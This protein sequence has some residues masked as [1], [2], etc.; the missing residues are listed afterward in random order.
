MP[1]A[2]MAP[3]TPML[4]GVTALPVRPAGVA[5]TAAAAQIPM[6]D[7]KG[8]RLGTAIS[9][10]LL[11]A[12]YNHN[13]FISQLLLT[14][15]STQGLGVVSSFRFCCPFSCRVECLTG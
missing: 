14:G 15:D 8:F 6:P 4:P 10:V 2:P 3:M 12:I 7:S 9:G 1:L 5:A 13:I 11:R